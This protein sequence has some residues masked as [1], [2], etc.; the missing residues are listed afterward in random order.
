MQ[1][2]MEREGRREREE[3]R[4]EWRDRGVQGRTEGPGKEGVQG[5]ERQ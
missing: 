3:E 4:E 2:E 1:E 5:W